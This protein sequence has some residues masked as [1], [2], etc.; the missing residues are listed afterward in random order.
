MFLRWF[1]VYFVEHISGMLNSNQVLKSDLHKQLDIKEH[2]VSRN[3][4][5]MANNCLQ[6]NDWLLSKNSQVRS[7]S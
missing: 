2:S 5:L 3:D 1:L 6:G 7:V 4:G